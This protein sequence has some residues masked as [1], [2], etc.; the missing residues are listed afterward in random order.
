MQSYNFTD[1]DSVENMFLSTL[2]A[3]FTVESLCIWKIWSEKGKQVSSCPYPWNHV[4]SRVLTVSITWLKIV[5]YDS[6]PYKSAKVMVL[7]QAEQKSF[8]NH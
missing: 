4:S 7:S 5:N 2:S 8:K 3:L 6:F 1:K